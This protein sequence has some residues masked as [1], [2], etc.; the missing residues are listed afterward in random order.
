MGY[1]RLLT[2]KSFKCPLWLEYFVAWVGCQ[3]GQGDPI[4]WVSTHRCGFRPAPHG[5]A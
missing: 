4:E 3:A 1:H 2:H 5:W